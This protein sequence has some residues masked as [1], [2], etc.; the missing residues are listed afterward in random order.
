MPDNADFQ[1]DD[2]LAAIPDLSTRSLDGVLSDGDSVLDR[3]VLRLLH[4]LEQPGEH[5]AAHGNTLE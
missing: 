3:A 5:Y 1:R 2:E 4:N